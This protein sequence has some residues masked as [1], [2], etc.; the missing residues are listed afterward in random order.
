MKTTLL[1]SA[2]LSFAVLAVGSFWPAQTQDRAGEAQLSG[3]LTDPSGSGLGS[4]RI[5]AQL[6]GA[7][8]GSATSTASHPDGAYRLRLPPG[9]YHLHFERA[10]FVPRDFVLDLAAAENRTLDLRLNLEPLASNVVVTA[11]TQP[12]ELGHTPAPVDVVGQEE[13]AERQAV[14]LSDLLAT[15][16]GVSLARTGP[17]GGLATLFIDGGDSAF[18][19]VLIDGTPINLPGG[20]M[21]FSNLTV[22]NVDK[23]EVVHGAESAL[24][25]SDAMSGVIQIISHQGSTQTPAIELFAEGGGFSSARAGAQVSGRVGKFDYSAAGS[26]F[27]TDGQGVDDGFF[28]RS[29]AGN[30]GYSFS[31]ASQLRLT[32][33]SNASFAGTPGQTLLGSAFT[34]ATAFDDLRQLSGN[35]SWVFKT[36][37]HWVHRVSGMEARFLDT[38]GFPDF[39]FFQT[40]QFNRAG[41]LEQSTYS[42]RTGAATAGYQYEVEN[43]DPNNLSGLHAR[44]NNQAGFLDARW[45]PLARLTLSAGAR[46]EANTNFGTRVVPRVGGVY[47]LRFGNGFWLE[48]RLNARSRAAPLT[49]VST[50]F[51]VAI[52][53]VFPSVFLTVSFTISSISAWGR[54]ILSVSVVL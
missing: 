34:D 30:F 47:A 1:R 39:S 9:R 18:T 27:H 53:F 50:S 12:T 8:S 40:A 26:Y 15:Q 21:N 3:K 51:S 38:A 42:F 36:G 33:R 49:S 45:L 23:V 31:D 46:A 48:T 6:E 17:I 22:D 54:P 19:K 44:R 16:T 7:P 14:S 29:L 2:F 37:A 5:T 24:Y 43:A 20:D 4:V 25:G 35:L 13:I 32:V 28:N 41:F 10:S 52:V 11:N